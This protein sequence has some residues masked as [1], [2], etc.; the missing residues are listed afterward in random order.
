MPKEVIASCKLLKVAG[1]E[2]LSEDVVLGMPPSITCS[3]V[4]GRRG[5][6]SLHKMVNNRACFLGVGV[7]ANRQL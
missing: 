2:H 1:D 7:L 5:G 6:E 3:T 4:L